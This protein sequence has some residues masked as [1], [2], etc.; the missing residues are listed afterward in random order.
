MRAAGAELQGVG[1]TG[2]APTRAG[3]KMRREEGKG[4]GD[5]EEA[6]SGSGVQGVAS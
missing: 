2:G 3:G 6:V 5:W 1:E 4:E